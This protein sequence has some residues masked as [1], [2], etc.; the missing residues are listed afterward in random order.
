[1]IESN[2]TWPHRL[3]HYFEFGKANIDLEHIIVCLA[4]VTISSLIFGT[5]LMSALNKDTD[6]LKVIRKNWRL[7]ISKKRKA[8]KSVRQGEE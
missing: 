1:M 2:Q 7:K 3:D 5:I 4:V 6:A 8:V